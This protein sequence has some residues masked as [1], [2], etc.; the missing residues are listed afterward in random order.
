[1]QKVASQYSIIAKL[2][3][4][5]IVN[6]NIDFEAAWYTAARQILTSESS[7]KKGCPRATFVGLCESGNL[8][9]IPKTKTSDSLNYQYAKYA[10]QKW[11][12]NREI[13]KPEMWNLVKKQF[14]KEIS[15]QG[16]LDVVLGLW[17]Y[18]V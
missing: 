16:Q 6:L 9:G 17:D 11:K 13:S 14:N 18:L 10:I 5:N 7:I 4:D 3:Y 15:Q 1:M 12:E 8:K 2:A